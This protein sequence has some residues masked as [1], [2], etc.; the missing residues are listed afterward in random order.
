GLRAFNTSSGTVKPAGLK[1]LP[2]QVCAVDIQ[3]PMNVRFQSGEIDK[4]AVVTATDSITGYCRSA[5]IWEFSSATVMHQLNK[6]FLVTDFPKVCFTDKGSNLSSKFAKRKFEEWNCVHLVLPSHP[7]AYSGFF[8][9]VHRSINDGLRS[10]LSYRMVG[11]REEVEI[12]VL[13]A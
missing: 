5:V 4:F 3:G 12:A 7:E 11:G 8:E 2:W 6:L 13:E 1:F 10:M 9:I